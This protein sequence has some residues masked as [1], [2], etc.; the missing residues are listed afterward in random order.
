MTS[1]V[2]AAGFAGSR[3]LVR[4]ADS[5]AR[6]ST[7]A[8]VTLAVSGA[9][10]A[11]GVIA[12]VVKRLQAVEVR[13]G[14]EAAAVNAAILRAPGDLVVLINAPWRIESAM[15]ERCAAVLEADPQTAAVIPT[16]SLQTADGLQLRTF[17]VQPTL[18]SLL[19]RPLETPPVFL[20]RSS[21]W[22]RLGSLDENAGTV[23]WCEWWLRFVGA[24][25]PIAAL[26]DPLASLA[27]GERDWWPPL[28]PDPLDLVRYRAV[29]EKHRGLIDAQMRDIVVEQEIGFGRLLARHREALQAR[30]RLLAKLDRVRAQA[31]HHLAYLDHH[32]RRAVEWGDLRRLDPVSRDWGYDR[33]TPIDRRYIEEFLA[34]HSSDVGGHVLE[35]QEDDFTRRFGG[36]RV[37]RSDVLDVDDSNSR[38]TVVADLRAAVD[39]PDARFDC[40]ILTQTLHVIDDMAAAI[41]E[42]HR[43]LKPG[44]VV[45]ATLPSASRVCLE[46]GTDGD[47]WRLTSAGCR[48]LFERTFE[49]GNVEL[50]TFGSVLTNVAFLHGVACAELTDQEFQ[51][52]DP[53]HPLLVGVR[54][55]KRANGRRSIRRHPGIVLLYH[56]VDERPDV[57]DLAIPK[58]LL[59]E[60]L[61]W[62]SRECTV[63]PLEQL[64]AD[65][66]GGLPERA[67]AITFDDGY[68]DTLEAA[69][70]ILERL[71]LPATVFA[72]SRWLREPGEYWWDILERAILESM[73]SAELTLDFRGDHFFFP[74]LTPPDRRAAH[75]RLHARLVR[76]SLDERDY[77]LAQIVGWSR[78]TPDPRRRPVVAD[79]LQR[80]ARVPGISIGAHGVDHLALPDQGPEAQRSE[81]LGSMQALERVLS[82][83]IETFA[84]PYGS[85]DRASADLARASCRWS[86]G[87]DPR[88]VGPSFDAAN[89]PRL[90]VKRWDPATL[91][92]HIERLCRGANPPGSATGS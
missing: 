89:V 43:I 59:E 74:V 42:C 23:A 28:S 44:G 69:A 25:I 4:T 49:P 13:A 84:F 85:V 73:P 17:T 31:A 39:L 51:S 52:N 62:L 91:S 24:G 68:L 70:P 58:G 5:V 30:D 72:T 83:R 11:V 90:E 46:Y 9:G 18:S 16:F 6:Q 34:A 12:S 1:V 21:V 7:A 60:Q 65:A 37:I 71:G 3:A 20:M 47:L 8:D 79:E 22:K 15:I 76:A 53:Y 48:A 88:P 33:G 2:I 61:D 38:A 19:A 29:L 50:S 63:M 56:R 66:T 86:A 55:Q 41:G 81:M 92:G 26:D 54:A 36:P 77:V 27:A 32:G 35:V 67:V 78:L 14:T 64:L 10:P 82:T 75:D 45:L 80:L 57:H 87:C 40:V